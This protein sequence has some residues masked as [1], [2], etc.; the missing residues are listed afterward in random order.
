MK[1]KPK[2]QIDPMRQ[3]VKSQ[4]EAAIFGTFPLMILIFAIA[5]K[6]V[7]FIVGASLLEVLIIAVVIFRILNPLYGYV[8][9]EKKL[10]KKR[11]ELKGKIN[12]TGF[13]KLFILSCN[14][15]DDIYVNNYLKTVKN[16]KIK[17][18]RIEPKDT[19]S[20]IMFCKY[21]GFDIDMIVSNDSVE[22]EIDSPSKYDGTKE[23]KDLEKKRYHKIEPIHNT[24]IEALVDYLLT[25]IEESSLI[26]DKFQST[27]EADNLINGRLIN[28]L[29]MLSGY[30]KL[31]GFVCAIIAPFLIA[32]FL[33]P[34]FMIIFG[35]EFKNNPIR[36]IFSIIVCG[37]L[38][39]CMI[40]VFIYGLNYIVK[41]YHMKKDIS[42][43]RVNVIEEKPIKVRLVRDQ[44]TRYCSFR[45]IRYLVLYYSHHRK[46]ILP[47]V[48]YISFAPKHSIKNAYNECLQN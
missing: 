34:I 4:I 23:N 40:F 15:Q 19:K 27:N 1:M 11:D 2:K 28:K 39:I 35:D 22:W 10:I 46:L 3:S 16:K 32:L 30:M 37:P 9:M 5:S 12:Q 26:I 43:K 7:F 21:S 31:E 47:F 8:R 25:I 14:E 42:N 20:L 29:S 44:K 13:E 24:S 41:Y 18:M 38:S 33:S 17:T 6:N 36:T 45:T 48:E